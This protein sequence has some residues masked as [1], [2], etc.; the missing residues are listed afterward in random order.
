MVYKFMCDA[1]YFK[2]KIA[3]IRK[4]EQRHPKFVGQVLAAIEMLEDTTAKLFVT[5]RYTAATVKDL[6]HLKANCREG[7]TV[8]LEKGIQTLLNG[9]NDWVPL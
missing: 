8:R 6:A 5:M 7:S 9:L 2:T 1:P 3:S 4:T